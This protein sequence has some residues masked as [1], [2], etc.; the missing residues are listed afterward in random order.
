MKQALMHGA[1]RLSQSNM[2]EQG[3]GRL[4]LVQS[5]RVLQSYTP[6]EMI[7]IKVLEIT[8]RLLLKNHDLRF[9]FN[10]DEQ[11]K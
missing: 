7:F 2:F 1:T 8:V 10:L 4:N 6:Q 11:V 5:W 9:L 3:A